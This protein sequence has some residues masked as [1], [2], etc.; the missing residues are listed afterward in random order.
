MDWFLA[1]R[2]QGDFTKRVSKDIR[3]ALANSDLTLHQATRFMGLIEAGMQEFERFLAGAKR[4][5]LPKAYYDAAAI[6]ESIWTALLMDAAVRRDMIGSQ[7]QDA[8][9]T[10]AQP[11]P[12]M[13]MAG[14]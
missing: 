7:E 2:K 9:R 3:L 1:L 12:N 5:E 4:Q 13:L 8:P 14:C 11:M 10:T 6:L